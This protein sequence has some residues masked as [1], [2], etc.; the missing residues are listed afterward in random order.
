MTTFPWLTPFIGTDVQCP[1]KLPGHSSGTK[2]PMLGIWFIGPPEWAQILLEVEQESGN[3]I[4]PIPLLPFSFWI[5]KDNNRDFKLGRQ[6]EVTIT[7]ER[8]ASFYFNGHRVICRV[9]IIGRGRGMG[10]QGRDS[11]FIFLHQ[12][13]LVS[14]YPF[15]NAGK[16]QRVIL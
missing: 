10:A 3:H 5:L 8:K 14:F 15:S 16:F 12:L 13:N 4:L 7:W 11:L 1:S 2:H 9:R 6:L